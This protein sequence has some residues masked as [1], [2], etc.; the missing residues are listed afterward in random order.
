MTELEILFKKFIEL[1]R[2]DVRFTTKS[3]LQELDDFIGDWT[4]VMKKNKLFIQVM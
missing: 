1:I 2:E 3:K 4:K